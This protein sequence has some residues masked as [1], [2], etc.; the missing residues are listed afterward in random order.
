MKVSNEIINICP[1]I[2]KWRHELHT[3]ELGYEEEWTSNFVAKKLESFGWRFIEEWL[4]Q[5]LLEF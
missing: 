1:E 4:K 2:K 5:V 3:S